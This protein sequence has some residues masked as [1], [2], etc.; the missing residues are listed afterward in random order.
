V[1]RADPKRFWLC[2]IGDPARGAPNIGA[3]DVLLGADRSRP[4]AVWED[5]DGAP[6]LARHD[7]PAGRCAVLFDGRLVNR[8]PV[9]R[10]AAGRDA[11]A[12]LAG[13]NPAELSDAELILAA[14]LA[15][16][17]RF[18][19]VLRG[20]FVLTI[21]DAR[22]GTVVV[23]RDHMGVQPVFFAE[24]G[25]SLVVSPS[26]EEIAA[27]GPLPAP[28]LLGLA[29]WVLL[30]RTRLDETL[31]AGVRRLPQAHLLRADGPSTSISRYWTPPIWPHTPAESIDAGDAVTRFDE[32]LERAV[33]RCLDDRP[34][35]L[36]LSGG[37]DSA[38]IAA[39]ARDVRHALGLHPPQ[40]LSIVFPDPESNEEPVQRAVAAALG[41]PQVVVPLADAV[42]LDGVLLAGLETARRSWQPC[43]NPWEAA[44]DELVRRAG[45]DGFA[46]VLSGA[47]GNEVLEVPWGWS[48]DLL[49]RGDV[50]RLAGFAEALAGYFG[51][52]RRSYLTELLWGSGL[53]PLLRDAAVARLPRTAVTRVRAA[54]AAQWAARLPG[55]AV[56]DGALRRHVIARRHEQLP[57]RVAGNEAARI[58]TLQSPWDSIFAEATFLSCVRTGVSQHAPLY[59]PDVVTAA[60]AAPPE[61]LLLRG[62]MKGIATAVVRSRVGSAVPPLRAVGVSRLFGR[63][64]DDDG[65]IALRQMHGLRM[66]AELGI[67]TAASA[68]AAVAAIG[69]ARAPGYYERWQ[70]LAAE[71]W[72]QHRFPL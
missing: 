44:Y 28:S 59:D 26:P 43:I 60:F 30:G 68:G 53:R 5:D 4:L 19:E 1:R 42:G 31:F 8:E 24:R 2:V 20:A 64:L 71:A 54:R 70:V 45:Q 56:P 11:E 51:G 33:E 38:I 29:D 50:R 6:L 22:D 21:W 41:L 25:G 3:P 48:A 32:A 58:R 72:L 67:V 66:L 18:V 7:M 16:G 47:G 27:S 55:W 35:A 69:G 40:A 10:L 52:R 63:I 34:T 17:L 49:R 13:R 46:T 14:Y 15:C 12:P 61:S 39:V 9:E 36:F 62:E 65:P 23:A 57:E 37:V